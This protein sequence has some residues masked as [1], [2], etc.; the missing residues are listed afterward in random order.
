MVDVLGGWVKENM[1][2]F[3][4]QGHTRRAASVSSWEHHAKYRLPHAARGAYGGAL[5][6][7]AATASGVSQSATLNI[8]D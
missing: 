7:A 1:K 3:H 5:L 4:T 6:A 2:P 8:N